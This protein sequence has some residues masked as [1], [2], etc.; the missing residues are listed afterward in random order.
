VQSSRG[1]V[2][3]VQELRMKSTL[4]SLY[5][6]AVMVLLIKRTVFLRTLEL[7]RPVLKRVVYTQNNIQLIQKRDRV[8]HGHTLSWFAD[9]RTR[10]NTERCVQA[11]W[12]L[13]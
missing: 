13:H 6:Y 10:L 8:C 2:W 9:Y 11:D 12:S 3:W 7:C 5:N 1:E 4:G